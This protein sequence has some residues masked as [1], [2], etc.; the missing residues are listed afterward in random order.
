MEHLFLRDSLALFQAIEATHAV[1]ASLVY[2]IVVAR[3]GHARRVWCPC[4]DNL[5]PLRGGASIGNLHLFCETIAHVLY[6]DTWRCECWCERGC[7]RLRRRE[8]D[9]AGEKDRSHGCGCTANEQ[10]LV[11]VGWTDRSSSLAAKGSMGR[12][13]GTAPLTAEDRPRPPGICP[14]RHTTRALRSMVQQQ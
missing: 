8:H 3:Q 4:P 11:P 10:G 12:H 9:R 1:A 6:L 13:R 5:D 7:V 14:A 2:E